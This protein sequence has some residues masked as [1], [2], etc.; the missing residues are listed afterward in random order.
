MRRVYR[1]LRLH[2][3]SSGSEPLRIRLA[4]NSRSI[5]TRDVAHAICARCEAL[6]H[7]VIRIDA[8]VETLTRACLDGA[9]HD[10]DMRGSWRIN[11]GR[12][13]PQMTCFIEDLVAVVAKPECVAVFDT[14]ETQ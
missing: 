4:H 7:A 3:S 9:A 10:L 12:T 5:K 1:N 6:G 14:G 2:G 8:D 13:P 11:A